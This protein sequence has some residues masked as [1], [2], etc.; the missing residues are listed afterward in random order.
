MMHMNK[1]LVTLAFSMLFS[2]GVSAAEEDV[3]AFEVPPITYPKYPLYSSKGAW[4][5]VA[6]AIS[7]KVTKSL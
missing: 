6:Q 5:L 1:L 7:T 4:G 2:N 3:G